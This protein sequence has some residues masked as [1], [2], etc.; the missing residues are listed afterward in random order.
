MVNEKII[1]KPEQHAKYFKVKELLQS[2]NVHFMKQSFMVGKK[3][4]IHV[5]I[6]YNLLL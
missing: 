2:F 4:L 3:K 5:T 6:R 1:K